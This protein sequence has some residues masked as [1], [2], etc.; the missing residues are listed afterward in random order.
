MEMIFQ[1]KIKEESDLNK[2]KLH[3]F[4]LRKRPGFFKSIVEGKISLFSLD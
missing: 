3:F 1:T 2:G 4:F